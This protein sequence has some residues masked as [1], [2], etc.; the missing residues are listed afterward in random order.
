MRSRGEEPPCGGP[1][2]PDGRGACGLE[3]GGLGKGGPTRT[4]EGLNQSICLEATQ[5]LV[6]K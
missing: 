3:R 2:Q 4:V 6:I 5:V 1:G